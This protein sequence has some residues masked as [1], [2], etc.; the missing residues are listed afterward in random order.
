MPATLVLA[1]GSPRRRELLERSGLTFEVVSPSIDESIHSAEAPAAYVERL[2]TQK[3]RVVASRAAASSIV[4]A[5]DTSVVLG[6]H[7]LA[8]PE[9]EREAIEMLTALSN[10]T[11]RVLTGV[12]V[13][14]A[15]LKLARVVE[16]E[17]VFC[18]LTTA[19][20]EWYVRTQEPMD[21]AGAYA[22]QGGAAMFVERIVGSVTNVIGLPLAE[23]FQMLEQA[24]LDLPWATR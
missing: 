20:I 15:S 13:R 4:V 23:T 5:A 21:K 11:H 14:S 3:A 2:A 9:S 22:I 16:T 10:K 7:I 1:S 17:V 18:P 6:S 19:Q 24:G 12:A 8:K